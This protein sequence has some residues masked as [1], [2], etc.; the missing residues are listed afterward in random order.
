MDMDNTDI[1]PARECYNLLI[2]RWLASIRY[3]PPRQKT[4]PRRNQAKPQVPPHR[5]PHKSM[6]EKRTILAIKLWQKLL[7]CCPPFSIIINILPSQCIYLINENK[8]RCLPEPPSL[9]TML[10]KFPVSVLN[11]KTIPKMSGAVSQL[12][13]AIIWIITL[14]QCGDDQ[15]SHWLLQW[16][17]YQRLCLN[18]FLCWTQ[19]TQHQMQKQKGA[20]F[21]LQ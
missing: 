3:S 13:R 15:G 2:W 1:S 5:H 6:N 17:I 11:K 4:E 20:H 14:S 12:A 21:L 16:R 18:H 19:Q 7:E 9:H 8:W 10:C